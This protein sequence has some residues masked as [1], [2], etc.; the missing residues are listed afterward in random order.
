MVLFKGTS[1]TGTTAG[2]MLL[3][4]GRVS[5]RI[6]YRLVTPVAENEFLTLFNPEYRQE[7][8]TEPMVHPLQTG[9]CQA[10]DRT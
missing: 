1:T 10:A 6:K 3:F 8:E 9:L 5:R 2:K 4:A 7:K